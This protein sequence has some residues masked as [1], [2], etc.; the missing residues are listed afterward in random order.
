MF[1]G[2]G[3]IPIQRPQLP[4]N[5]LRDLPYVCSSAT[6][7]ITK[8][9][10]AYTLLQITLLFL[11]TSHLMSPLFHLL[12][13]LTHQCHPTLNFFQSLMSCCSPLDPVLRLVFLQVQV[14]LVMAPLQWLPLLAPACACPK[15]YGWL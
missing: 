2:V 15:R 5:F 3:A 7:R 12:R 1:S 8:A 11:V 14:L 4:T 9:L 10:A 6:Q 13:N